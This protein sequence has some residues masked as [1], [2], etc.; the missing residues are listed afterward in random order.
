MQSKFDEPAIEESGPQW[1]DEC[2][3]A[4]PQPRLIISSEGLLV[5]A[6]ARARELLDEHV[7]AAP[8]G[9]LRFGSAESSRMF[10]ETLRSICGRPG[11]RARLLVKD[12]Q[13]DWRTLQ[14]HTG[15]TGLYG[16]VTLGPAATDVASDGLY[17]VVEAFGLT[18]AEAQVL[19]ELVGDACPKE[20]A[21]KLSLS[22]HTVR[23][24][25]RSIYAK[26]GVRGLTSAVRLSMQLAA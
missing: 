1:S 10:G 8:R 2:F 21:R 14:L 24:H 22:E 11:A 16:F 18:R 12:F 5:R 13:G 15:A 19:A 26:L 20:T 4:D 23:S 25:L 9:E 6:N 3:E 7:L 17:A